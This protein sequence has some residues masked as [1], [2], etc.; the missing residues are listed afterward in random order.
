MKTKVNL[1]QYHFDAA[2]FIGR[3]A[4]LAKPRMD[5]DDALLCVLLLA[6]GVERLLKGM[7][8][9]INPVF[10]FNKMTFN[11]AFPLLAYELLSTLPTNMKLPELDRAER[12]TIS[13]SQAITRCRYF[14]STVK[15]HEALLRKLAET[16]DIIAHGETITVDRQFIRPLL[17]KEFRP[18][19]SQFTE[20]L[21][22]P[23]KTL[24]T[25]LPQMLCLYED[26]PLPEPEKEVSEVVKEKIERHLAEWNKRKNDEEF[27]KRQSVQTK[28]VSSVGAKVLL[29]CPA[30]GNESILFYEPDFDYSDGQAWLSGFYATKLECFFCGITISKYDEIDFLNLNQVFREPPPPKKLKESS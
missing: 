18:L 13:L 24:Y 2:N 25:P 27:E 8:Y 21:G 4:Q 19:I 1:N 22:F 7:L 17:I 14:S 9:N 23:E 30:C 3:V 15:T 29:A 28:A 26:E 16:R 20:E 6:I 10:V 5:D 11:N 12:E